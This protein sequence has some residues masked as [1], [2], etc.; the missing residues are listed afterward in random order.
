MKNTFLKSFLIITFITV[1]FSSCINSDVYENI[2]TTCTTA[3]P[4]KTVAGIYD[5][6]PPPPPPPQTPPETT[7]P[8]LYESDDIIEAYVTSSDAG[9]TFYKSLSMVSIDGT[10]AFS[11]PIDM[12]NIYTEYEPGRKVYVYLKDRYFNKTYGSLII[13]DLYIND[14]KETIGRIQPEAMRN[15]IKA[16]C[17]S[18]SDDE[19]VQHMTISEALNNNQINKLIQI[20]NVQFGDEALS[21]NYYNPLNVIGGAT[22]ISIVDENGK[23]MIFRTSEFADFANVLVAPG[24]G[25]IRGVLT[26]YNSDFQFLARTI[27]DI[28]FNDPRLVPVFEE[29][30]TNNFPLWTKIS[31]VGA[32]VWTLDTQYGNPGSCAKMS[33]FASG[34]K[35]NDDWLISPVINLSGATAASLTFDTATK[36]AGNTLEILISAD[37][38]GSGTPTAATWT[39][40]TATLSP[41]S[42][43]YVWTNSGKIDISDFAG[44]KVYVAFKYTSTTS[45]A[46]TWEVDNVKVTT[47]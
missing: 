16:S 19:L 21:N 26:K 40:V 47:N 30:F 24:R 20:D 34:N 1:T 23:K 39:T 45:A 7:K 27:D 38:S 5:L 6:L 18:I 35:E 36:F 37:Y 25:S 4:T 43:S 2:D 9:G 31:L 33:G 17:E 28:Q 14:G 46:A 44:G 41:S 22:N 13:G 29:T 11:I 15:T 12:Y 10:K 32:Q 3:T 8:Q 42:G